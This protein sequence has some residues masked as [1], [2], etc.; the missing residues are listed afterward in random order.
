MQLSPEEFKVMMQPKQKRIPYENNWG[1]SGIKW[2]LKWNG[3]H[4]NLVSA[5]MDDP[6]PMPRGSEEGLIIQEI[7]IHR[8][9]VDSVDTTIVMADSMILI[10]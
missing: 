3:Q 10:R 7:S 6:L 2:N 1:W 9:V 8:K 4:D 5:V